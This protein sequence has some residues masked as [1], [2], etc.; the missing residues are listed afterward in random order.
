MYIVLVCPDCKSRSFELKESITSYDKKVDE[1]ICSKCGS[2]HF[3]G[4]LIV[5]LVREKEDNK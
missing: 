4:E 2:V 3:I 5:G 1:I